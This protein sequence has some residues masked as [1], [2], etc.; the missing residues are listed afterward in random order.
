M[1]R[2]IVV[3]SN[4]I[5]DDLH[6]ADGTCRRGIVGGAAVHA[7]VGARFWWP[8]VGIVAGVGLDFDAVA[9][10]ALARR[11]V[12]TGGCLVR[13]AH[14][15]ASTLVYDAAGERTETPVHGPEH[16]ERL[17]TTPR[18]VPEPWLP[19]AGT[20][21]FRDLLPRFWT[22]YGDVRPRL[23]DVLWEL[24]A[25][26][27]ER[28]YWPEIRALVPSVRIFSLNRTEGRALLGTGAPDVIADHVLDAG[29]A[30]AVVRLG[31]EGA[32]VADAET[33]LRVRPARGPVVDVTGAGNAFCGGF[34]A[35]WCRSPGDLEHAGRCGAAA[36]ARTIARLGPADPLDRAG[37]SALAAEVVVVPHSRSTEIPNA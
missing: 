30:V 34:L 20:Y 19:A 7:A 3:M 4:V 14:T 29:A 36:A 28:R 10:G 32:L 24:Q 31:S 2:T 26:V 17:Q 18:D 22:A 33:R 13:D 11:G 12:L 37:L 16:F 8:E 15:I 1:T 6:F 35:G 21:V 9:G 25:D 27:A 23:G 5:V